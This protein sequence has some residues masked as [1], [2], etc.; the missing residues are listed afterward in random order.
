MKILNFGSLNLDHSYRMDHLVRPGE[1]AR[2]SYYEIFHG[3]KGHNQSIALAKAGLECWHAGQIGLDGRPMLEE[4]RDLGINTN[5]CRIVKEASGH[6]VI[7]V[8]AKGENSIIFYPGANYR[9]D[10]AFIAEVFAGLPEDCR[11]LLLQNEISGNSRIMR[12]AKARGMRIILN[13]SPLNQAILDCPLDLAD[14]FLVNEDEARSLAVL[15]S[16]ASEQEVEVDAYHG[17]LSRSERILACLAERYPQAS[18]LLTLGKQGAAF[19]CH[20]KIYTQAAFPVEVVDTTGAGDCFAGF[21]LAHLL[22]AL[23]AAEQGESSDEEKQAAIQNALRLASLAASISI[24]RPGAAVSIP[25]LEEVL[26][27]GH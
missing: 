15:P 6:T 23:D 1:T 21:F 24:T 18:V 16:A 17:F 8:D 25:T 9:I 7:Q 27:A 11:Y 5:F 20:D 26:A 12:L 19:R 14:L 2:A 10:E 22:P 4:M 3:G 13:P